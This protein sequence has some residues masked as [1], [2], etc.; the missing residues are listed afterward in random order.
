MNHEGHEDHEGTKKRGA[1]RLRVPLLLLLAAILPGCRVQKDPDGSL[2]FKPL[3][4][5]IGELITMALDPDDADKRREGIVGLSQ[6]PW[7]L[8]ETVSVTGKD[9]KQKDVEVLKV[10]HLIASNTHEDPTVR[11]VA[12]NAL[13][14][15]GNPKYVNT[16][17][18][19]LGD[20][21]LPVRWDAAVAL[22]RVVGPPAAKPLEDHA[23]R[24]PSVDVRA[25]CA[26]ALRHYPQ[27]SI[28]E[29]LCRCLLDRDFS[30]RFQAHASL[31]E[32]TGKDRGYD[33]DDWFAAVQ[34]PQVIKP[35]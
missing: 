26:K 4:K 24:D 11:A 6:H 25:A 12:V 3:E 2:K 21:S 34:E 31:V 20:E 15:A 27:K 17:V 13:G 19:C 22:D 16:V 29:S 18:A 9:G 23:M 30:V 32:V 7:G 5:S 14:R 10:Y 35:K 28:M 8:R 1:V 33:S